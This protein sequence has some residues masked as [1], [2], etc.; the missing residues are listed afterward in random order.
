MDALKHLLVKA[1]Q[2]FTTSCG[3]CATTSLQEISGD[4][5]GIVRVSENGELSMLE[6]DFEGEDGGAC[7]GCG[8]VFPVDQTDLEHAGYRLPD[9]KL[10]YSLEDTLLRAYEKEM[11]VEGS[12]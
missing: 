4:I 5:V 11:C 1:T 12:Q 8:S 10:E 6:C 3:E 2:V 7:A 9:E